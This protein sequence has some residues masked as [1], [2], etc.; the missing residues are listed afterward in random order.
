MT[1]CAFIKCNQ[2]GKIPMPMQSSLNPAHKGLVL[3]CLPHADYIDDGGELSVVYT[4][5]TTKGT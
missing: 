5:Q 4:R 1:S 3:L 2:D